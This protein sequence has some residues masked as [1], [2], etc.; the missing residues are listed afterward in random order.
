M[1]LKLNLQCQPGSRIPINYA[2]ECSAWIYKTLAR[3]DPEFAAWLHQQGYALEGN[4]RFKFFT[5]SQLDLHPPFHIEPERQSIRIES[6]SASLILSFLLN[7]ALGHFVT[8]LFRQQRFGIGNAR[9]PATDFQVQHVEVLDRP[10]FT[11]TMRFRTLSPI[12][13]AASEIGKTHA[14]Y[15]RPTD[16]D[17]ASLLS[18]NLVQKMNTA[19]YYMQDTMM[20]PVHNSPLLFDLQSDPHQKGITLKAH[21]PAATKVIG[22]N[23]EFGITAPPELLEIGY[24]AGFGTENAQGFGCVEIIS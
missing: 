21:T 13:V 3:A 24:Y 14:Q 10:T 15:R 16:A 8:G 20:H 12:C 17:Y 22:Y 2:Y 6:G 18:K 19:R 23:Y 11:H 5:F 7:D 9:I 4:K 1:R